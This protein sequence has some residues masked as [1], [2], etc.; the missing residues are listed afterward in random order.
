LNGF[1]ITDDADYWLAYKGPSGWVHYNNSTKKWEAG[2]GVTHQGPLMTLNNKKVFQ[3]KLSPGSY[4][5]YFGVDLDMNGKVTKS[6]L[7]KDE[8]KVTVTSN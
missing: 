2:L 3:A 6:S 7:Y 1:G 8:V 5:F 4:T